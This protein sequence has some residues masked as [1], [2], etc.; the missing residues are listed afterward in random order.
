MLSITLSISF[1][2]ISS[3]IIRST[4]SH[5]A[6]V[7]SM[8][9]AVGARI[10]SLICPASTVGK[11]S[12]PSQGSSAKEQA[13]TARKPNGKQN[14]VREALLQDSTVSVSQ[15]FETAIQNVPAVAPADSGWPGISAPIPL[16]GPS[17]GTGPSSAPVSG[18]ASTRPASRKRRPRRAARTGSAPRR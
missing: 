12:S 11:K 7:S 10:C 13:H 14:P 6:A 4:S 5:S 16:R 9:V 3:R 15:L 18:K 17:A 2:G 8:R 1:A